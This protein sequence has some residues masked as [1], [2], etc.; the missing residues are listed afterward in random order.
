MIV[1]WKISRPL[2]VERDKVAESRN[3]NSEK[4]H[5]RIVRATYKNINTEP[6][7]RVRAAII[8]SRLEEK[9]T[10]MGEPA[11]NGLSWITRRP[12][13]ASGPN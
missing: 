12:I 11:N 2:K 4:I 6:R 3:L 10:R 13:G 9:S 8:K 1:I 7:Y 5:V